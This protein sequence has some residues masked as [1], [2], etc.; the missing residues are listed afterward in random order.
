MLLGFFAQGCFISG[1]SRL[2]VTRSIRIGVL[3]E[4]PHLIHLF[5][6]G[7]R[8]LAKVTGNISICGE[9]SFGVLI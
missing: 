4:R 2:W 1:E 8:S 5:M 3:V 7:R 9:Q 6:Y